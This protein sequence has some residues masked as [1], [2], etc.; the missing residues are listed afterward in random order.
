MPNG[1]VN[2]FE[3]AFRAWPIL[4]ATAAKKSTIAY[5]GLADYLTRIALI[6]IPEDVRKMYVRRYPEHEGEH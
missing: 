1:R 5:A 2:Q 4:T 6:E 3:R